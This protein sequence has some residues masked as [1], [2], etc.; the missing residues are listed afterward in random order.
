[1]ASFARR[2]FEM[3]ANGPKF[4][5]SFLYASY[6]RVRRPKYVQAKAAEFAFYQAVIGDRPATLIFDIGANS[7]SKTAQFVRLAAQVVSV[8]P[9]P[10]A[11]FVLRQRFSGNAHVHIVN[12]GVG[13]LPGSA[14]FFIF[15]DADA[16]NTF[17]E[18]WVESLGQASPGNCRPTKA[19]KAAIDVEITTL[20]RL[21]S[22]FGTP[23]YI[24]V[25][26]E[27]YEAQVVRGLSRKIPLLSF[28]CNLPEY[29]G[30]AVEI[31][32]SLSARDNSA[33]FNFVSSEPPVA[34]ECSEW[35]DANEM[36]SVIRSSGLVYAEVYCRSHCGPS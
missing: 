8:E 14:K 16:Y 1:M 18:K 11:V 19:V 21:I 25:D 6:L 5:D 2:L 4:N 26:V 3:V 20:D 22:E 10:A 35:I 13:A 9:S 34:F 17:S 27:G 23:D 32:Q 28:E 33:C 15:D 30:E 24:K 36:T 7:G 31:V 12:K 29:Q